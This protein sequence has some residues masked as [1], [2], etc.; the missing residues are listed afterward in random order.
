[1][2][3]AYVG[4]FDK[5]T[6]LAIIN[7]RIRIME[8]ADICDEMGGGY[9]PHVTFFVSAILDSGKESSR[10]SNEVKNLKKIDIALS[11]FGYFSNNVSVTYL[12]IEKD[13]P[14]MDFYYLVH[15]IN[16]RTNERNHLQKIEDAWVPHCTLLNRITNI[17]Y[18]TLTD[19]NTPLI[20]GKL[21]SIGI[22]EFPNDRS[23]FEEMLS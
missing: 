13:K 17:D 11:R 15:L 16:N 10:F 22:I 4:Y 18:K 7:L 14:L 1:M 9:R 19:K 12:C 21:S 2:P 23:V 20:K 5:E 3:Y 8:D 6:E